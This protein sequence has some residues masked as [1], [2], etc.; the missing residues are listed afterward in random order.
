MGSD[1]NTPKSHNKHR[2]SNKKIKITPN[3]FKSHQITS[4]YTHFHIA[5]PK[6]NQTKWIL[7]RS[8]ENHIKT[9]I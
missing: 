6:L 1:Q 2:I 4:N 5:I 7:I 9:K 3:H 8:H